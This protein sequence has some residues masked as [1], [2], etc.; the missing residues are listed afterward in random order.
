MALII[1]NTNNN[2]LYLKHY[3]LDCNEE[4]AI[5]FASETFQQL[6]IA[7]TRKIGASSAAEFERTAA[8]LKRMADDLAEMP[9]TKNTMSY[10]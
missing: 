6:A 5:K 9:A 10:N 3:S 7:I 4:D 2:F 1:M 8:V